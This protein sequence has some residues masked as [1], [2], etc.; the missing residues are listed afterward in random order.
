VIE[1]IW[2]WIALTFGAA[3]LLRNV[4]DIARSVH[5]GSAK[6]AWY[7]EDHDRE[8]EQVLFWVIIAG[9]VLSLTVSAGVSALGLFKLLGVI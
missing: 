5:R 8:D 2:P 7:G 1:R 6:A 9:K 4:W 3:N